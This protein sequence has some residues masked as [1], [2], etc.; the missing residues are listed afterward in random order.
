MLQKK[1]VAPATFDLLIRLQEEAFTSSMRLVGGTSLA[2]QI[3]HR[4]STDLDLFTTEPFNT[5]EALD[6]LIEKYHFTPRFSNK[7]SIIGFIDGVK[8]DMIYHPYPLLSG[9]ILP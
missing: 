3:A 4:T 2:L 6:Y 9:E 7:H 5:Q 8:V 1:T